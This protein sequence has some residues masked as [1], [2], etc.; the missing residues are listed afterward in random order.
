MLAEFFCDC[1]TVISRDMFFACCWRLRRARAGVTGC[2][3]ACTTAGDPGGAANE[4]G[5]WMALVDVLQDITVRR[6]T[7]RQL[8]T[9]H[10]AVAKSLAVDVR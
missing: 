3:T 5:Q 1:V 8:K 6:V 2:D 7:E 10:L 9:M 4:P